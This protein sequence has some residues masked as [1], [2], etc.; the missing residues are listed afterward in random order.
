[1][2]ELKRSGAFYTIMTR[3][4]LLILGLVLLA[5][6]GC[7]E[8]PSKENADASNQL[9]GNSLETIQKGAFVTLYYKGTLTDGSVFDQTQEGS[10]ATFQVGVGGLIQGFDDGLLGMKVGEK[11]TIVIPV[12]LAYG[13]INEEAIV[14]VPKQ[15]L[16]DA[17]I[18]VIVGI[19]VNASVGNGKIV[20]I[21]EENQTVKI[22]FNH[23]LAGEALTFE[24]EILGISETA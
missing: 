8:L 22:N 13:E 24:V 1:M 4:F 21:D 18:P 17:N 15:Q 12:A 16:V 14:D 2:I 9:G 23:P 19:T 11:K 7:T 10:P 3:A 6:A 5:L 20:S